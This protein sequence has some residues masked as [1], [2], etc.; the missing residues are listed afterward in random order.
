LRVVEATPST[1][2][3]KVAERLP[4]AEYRTREYLTPDEVEMLIKAA[5]SGRWAIATR[6]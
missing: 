1:E 6:A 5:K 2:N 3:R 4:N